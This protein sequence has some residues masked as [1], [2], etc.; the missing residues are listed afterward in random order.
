MTPID[1][2]Q[3]I[4]YVAAMWSQ[5]SEQAVAKPQHLTLVTVDNVPQR[6]LSGLIASLHTGELESD[7]LVL[8]D[9]ILAADFLQVTVLHGR[10][11]I[12]LF[13]KIR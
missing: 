2:K 3:R 5:I 11:G 10:I 4:P 6:I 7:E 13:Q 1:A 12:S 9:Q 8:A